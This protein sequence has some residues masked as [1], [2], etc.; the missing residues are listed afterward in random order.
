[1][2]TQK[3]APKEAEW[4]PTDLAYLCADCRKLIR[5]NSGLGYPI[6]VTSGDSSL[7]SVVSWEQHICNNAEKTVKSEEVYL[8]AEQNERERQAETYEGQFHSMAQFGK[9]R[10]QQL[11][12]QQLKQSQIRKPLSEDHKKN[13]SNSMHTTLQN[14]RELVFLAQTEKQRELE[15]KELER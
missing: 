14:K 15:K 10:E 8:N 7:E 1:M 4:N 13:I 9:D 2:T 12:Q 6:H 11:K 5:F 3:Q